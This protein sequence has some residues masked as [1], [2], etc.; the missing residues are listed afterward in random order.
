[1]LFNLF[2]TTTKFILELLQHTFLLKAF[3]IGIITAVTCAVVGNFLVASRQAIIADMLSHMALAGVGIGIFFSI[4]PLLT[5]I[6]TAFFSSF[7][8]VFFWNKK[9]FPPEAIAMLLLSGGLAI[10]VFFSHLSKNYSF[11]LESFLF[12]NILLVSQAESFWFVGINA[13]ILLILCWK[14]K[15]FF[16]VCLDK[17]F[18]QERFKNYKFFEI[19]FIW[20]VALLTCISLKV[21][22]G[23]LVGALLVIPVLASQVFSKSFLHSVIWSIFFN[24]SS[25]LLGIIFSFVFDIPT[26]SAI[27]FLLVLCFLFSYIIIGKNILK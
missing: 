9:K 21:I 20:I 4:H 27:V 24:T 25:V 23:L 19:I 16:I 22:G 17:S 1:M 15:I 26:S 11:S 18:A 14:W 7:I 8:L 12:G 3:L 10:I 5:A 13:F 6:L 2:T